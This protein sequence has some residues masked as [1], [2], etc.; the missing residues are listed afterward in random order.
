LQE[1]QQIN[2]EKIS[3]FAFFVD[4]AHFLLFSYPKQIIM[5]TEFVFDNIK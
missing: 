1:K 3:G 4:L 5:P 2:P